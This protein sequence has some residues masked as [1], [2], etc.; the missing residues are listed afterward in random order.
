MRKFYWKNNTRSKLSSMERGKHTLV[1]VYVDTPI[2]GNT[3][4]VN[5]I[6]YATAI[7]ITAVLIRK[8]LP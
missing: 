4:I 8:R 5:A 6:T 3:A 2:I 7:I 1:L